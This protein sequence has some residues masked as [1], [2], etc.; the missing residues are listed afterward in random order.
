MKRSGPPQRTVGLKRTGGPKRSAM[1]RVAAPLKRAATVAPVS[2]KRKAE[3]LERRQVVAMLRTQTRTCQ[4]N[5]LLGAA[6]RRM[7]SDAGRA[8]YLEG[9]KACYLYGPFVGHEPQ[10]RSRRGSIVDPA[11]IIIC[12]S[13]C[14]DWVERWPAAATEAGLLIPSSFERDGRA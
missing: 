12:C 14:N 6:L 3:N 9:L 2:A 5:A 1:S 13:P 10:K 4:A 7:T 11:N 8:P